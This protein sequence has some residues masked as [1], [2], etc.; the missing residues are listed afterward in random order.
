CH[1]LFDMGLAPEI[2]RRS[3]WIE[4]Q[5]AGFAP[6]SAHHGASH[7]AMLTGDPDELIGQIEDCLSAFRHNSLPVSVALEA[8][9]L[10]GH[11]RRNMAPSHP[12]GCLL[13]G[14]LAQH[15][16]P[17]PLVGPLSRYV[18]A[19]CWS[20]EGLK[21]PRFCIGKPMRCCGPGQVSFA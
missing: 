4:Q 7:H 15:S 12:S 5:L 10:P 8:L 1:P 3:A 6:E 14:S 9:Y 16:S 20:F 11:R 21:G 17:Q 2:D 13:E 18:Q 19:I